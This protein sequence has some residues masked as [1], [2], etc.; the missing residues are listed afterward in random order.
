ME[1]RDVLLATKLHVPRPQPGFVTRPRLTAQLDQGLGRRLILV[2]A[3]AGFGKTA[4][5]AAWAGEGKLPVAWLSLDSGDDDPARFWR[6]VTAALERACPGIGGQVGPLL[7]PPLPRSFEGV[8][9]VLINELAARP[10]AGRALLVLDDYHCVGAEQV[11]AELA[12]LIG[13]LP[14][15]LRVVL[16]T[17][18]DPPLPM[19]RLRA[20]GEL[21]ELRAADLRFTAEEAAALLAGALGAATP[22][23]AAP[24]LT[25]AAVTALTARTEGWA[26]GLRLAGLTLRDLEDVGAF[27]A[28]F[29][30]S[31]RYVLD[32]LAEEVLDRQNT[33]VR[34]FL[35]ETSVL[36]R[37]SGDLCDTVTGR[38][39]GQAM[40]E[41][42]EQA[43]LFLMALDEV[44]GWWRYHQLFADLLRARLHAEHP[45]R[46]VA[47]H[48]AAA[49]WHAVRGL[50]DD[51]VGHA[52]AAGQAEYA[53]ELIEQHFDA[54]YF[55]GENATLDRWLA[56]LPTDVVSRRPRLS[57]ARAFMALAAGE[58]AAARAAVAALGTDLDAA[59]D[60]FQPSAGPAASLITN[61][62]AAAA[63]ARGWLAYLC[64]DARQ[65]TEF[66]A[67]ATA[68]LHD[69]EWLLGSICRLNL[70][71]ADWVSGRLGDAR[72]NLSADVA[73]WR[74]TGQQ[75]MAAQGCRFLGQ[76]HCAQGDLDAALADY[77]ELLQIAAPT[78]RREPPVAGIGHLGAA[79]VHYQRGDLAAARRELAEG[80]PMCRKITETQA[81]GA[82]LATL[83]WI[84]QAEG[85]PAGA[86]AAIAEAERAGPN[87]AV[88]A[89]LN[90]VPAQRAR[91]LLAQGDVTAA[92]DW[93]LRRD[94]RPDDE[95]AYTSELD[96]LV[97]ARVLLAQDR[98]GPALGLLG[99]L[100][101]T[102]ES[103]G[104]TGSVIE[105]RALRALALARGGDE[106][107]AVAELTTALT[108]ASPR[109]HIRVF[110][111]EGT[112]MAAL[113]S[114][115]LAAQRRERQ[116][117]LGYLAT[118]LR[119]SRPADDANATAPGLIEPLTSREMQVLELLAAG[120]PNQRIAED[121]V[122]TLDTVKKHVTHL[123]GKLGAVNRTEAVA[124][125]RQL[126]LIS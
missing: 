21:A 107:A 90:P 102:A 3:P 43:G 69:G 9:T 32:Y 63:I 22:G 91:L 74:A 24:G 51:A 87:P 37:L 26:A 115:V 122:V 77:A 17:R 100:L 36:E 121:L 31:H 10:A 112:P 45:G 29:S 44:R 49:A 15:G 40:L 4:L 35:L 11:H 105:I 83:A 85:D 88:A 84:Q 104:R 13:H 72:Q 8:V 23:T 62:A 14:P 96:Y 30:G 66:A 16:S 39:G 109:G 101:S 97:L 81:L 47:L 61:V 38:P 124:R 118:I 113:L 110:A 98:H 111:D 126:G 25:S 28:A 41:R 46:A 53:A 80:L 57:L 120:S 79:E 114:Q 93:T 117:P 123:L 52:M 42:I 33:Q 95:P 59:G 20:R 71:L 65:M 67:Q 116:V 68:R 125:A 27:V 19:S 58:P 86:R 89:L 54:T 55:T 56:A 73:G 103:Q 5:L 48:R 108:L 1:S 70:A 7:A 75:A 60:S 64:G 12:F 34:T 76:I 2:C 119:A 50:A 82:G 6:H 94:L 99:R 78:G 18:S 106:T 92:A